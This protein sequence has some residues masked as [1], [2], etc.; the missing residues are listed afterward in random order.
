MAICCSSGGL[1]WIFRNVSSQKE[2]WGTGVPGRRESR[3]P[4]NF[5]RT[6]LSV[7]I[8]GTLH[9]V[10][11]ETLKKASVAQITRSFSSVVDAVPEL[12]NFSPYEIGFFFPPI[13]MQ[14]TWICTQL[15][16]SNYITKSI[17]QFSTADS[18]HRCVEELCIITKP[19]HRIVQPHFHLLTYM[20]KPRGYSCGT[21]FRVTSLPRQ[22][23]S[24]ILRFP[25]PWLVFKP[26]G[27]SSV[28]WEFHFFI[29][30]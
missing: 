28:L 19:C 16:L 21:L 24:I 1:G 25:L 12:I 18:H 23:P 5:S 14:F 2:W 4:Q 10:Q 17:L 20:F 13:Y 9:G 27:N 3:R 15:H 6:G 11:R 8:W 22:N 30:I 7:S 29:D 26:H